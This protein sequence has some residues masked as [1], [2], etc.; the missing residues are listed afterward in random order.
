MLR[1]ESLLFGCQRLLFS[2]QCVSSTFSEILLIVE[3]MYDFYGILHSILMKKRRRSTGTI[4]NPML[5]PR[6]RHLLFPCPTVACGTISGHLPV[7]L[8]HI[9]FTRLAINIPIG[10]RAVRV[11]SRF[12]VLGFVF[13]VDVP[14]G[15]G[16]LS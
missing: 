4:S 5:Y 6:A 11:S 13:G 8:C 1:A 10:G 3:R 2:A 16:G 12:V 9:R 15:L 14:A 7:S